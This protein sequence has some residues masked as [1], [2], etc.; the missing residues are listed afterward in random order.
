MALYTDYSSNTVGTAAEHTSANAVMKRGQTGIESDTG[1]SKVG[2]GVTAWTSLAYADEAGPRD[3]KRVGGA[4]S[5]IGFFGATPV[6]KPTV[7]AAAT[8]AATTQTLANDIR[9]A[10]IALGLVS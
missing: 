3:D 10:L 1:R 9:T 4:T 6:V 5:K 2:D 7:R 8:D